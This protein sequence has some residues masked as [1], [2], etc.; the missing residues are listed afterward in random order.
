[1]QLSGDRRAGPADRRQFGSLLDGLPD[2]AWML[3]AEGALLDFNPAFVAFVKAAGCREPERGALFRELV[4]GSEHEELWRDLTARVRGGRSVT[5]DV[6]LT[7]SG[8]ERA[9]TIHGTPSDDSAFF[10]AREVTVLHTLRDDSLEL[11]LMRLFSTEPTL[12]EALTSALTFLCASDAWDGAVVWL[13]EPPTAAADANQESSS[14]AR[15]VLAARAMWLH[16]SLAHA[17]A[18]RSRIEALRFTYGHGLPGRAWASGELIWVPDLFDESGLTRGDL[19]ARAGLHTVVAIPVVESEQ[20]IGVI[21]VFDHAVRPI[22]L[23]RAQSLRRVAAAIGRLAERRRADDE[24]RRLIALVERKG[25]EWALTFDAFQQPI[26]L[27][28]RDGAI[29]RLNR[30]ARDL[31]TAS[32][33]TDLL[34]RAIGSLGDGEP[35]ITLRDL[36]TAVA[37]SGESCTAHLENED[38]IFDV[39]ASLDADAQRVIL[40]L[41]DTT[42]VVRLQ[43]SVRRGEQL[44][45]L[46]ELVA[47]VA[48]QVKNPLFGIGMTVDL[49][50]QHVG[51]DAETEELFDALRKWLHRLGRLMDSLLAYGK[52]WTLDLRPH[53]VRD[54]IEQAIDLCRPAAA[55]NGVLIAFSPSADSALLMDPQRLVHAFENLITNAMQHAP[56]ESTVEVTLT[57]DAE[58]AEVVVTDQGPGF[59]EAD[60]PRIF[61]P[62]FTRRRGGTG[63]GL[64]IV[65][66]V[67]DEHG[68][69]VTAENGQTGGAVVR[70]RVPRYDERTPATEPTPHSD[71]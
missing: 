65:Q 52:T 23:P 17:D 51:K 66:R 16:E 10:V 38:A 29:V 36:V 39:D 70:V 60:L 5:A 37:E 20:T 55:A 27:T 25:H 35:W 1:M 34:G 15:G 8:I 12:D 41:R 54:V 50:Q 63:L 56:R 21:E 26:F 6:R 58:A 61:E 69:I 4:A 18:L 13:I 30:A 53:S 31:A 28:A 47:G 64:S 62:F 14:D 19:A 33:Y 40:T 2:P 22:S 44:A 67:V 59:R 71:R 57:I 43:E 46:G 11:A 48:H 32:S 45:A 68:G 49:L 42:E 7:T 24:R 3:D 9:Y